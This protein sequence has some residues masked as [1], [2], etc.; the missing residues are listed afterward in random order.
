MT[1]RLTDT[2]LALARIDSPSGSEARVAAYLTGI[3]EDAG[4]AVR[5]DDSRALTGADTGNLIAVIEGDGSSATLVLSA[6]MD[7]V[8]P[9][10]GVEPVVKEGVV[11]SAGE[12]VLG[13]DDK[14][15][16]AAI[17]EASRRLIESGVARP[18]IRLVITVSEEIGL[19]G[20]K[21]LD[22]HDVHGDLCLVLDA[23]GDPGGIVVAAPTHYTFAATFLG[24][25][26]HAG[27]YPELGH[28]AIE[29]AA[30]AIARMELGR[31]D[32]EST[33]NIG[34]IG[35]GGATNVVPAN[36]ELTGECR[37]LDLARVEEIRGRMDA[38]MRTAAIEGGGAVQ[39]AW[40]KEYDGYRF[41]E[42][43]AIL[44]LVTLAC[45]DAGLE[46]KTFE[47]GG[48]SDANIISALGVPT[49]ALSSGMRDVHSTS[50][51]IRLDDM[52][53][54]TRLVMAAAVRLVEE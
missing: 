53:A 28:S 46:P 12:T 13:A 4:F 39:I 41:A 8:Q 27:V 51:S 23:D 11:T 45:R 2:F 1:D 50:E 29:M 16:I 9:C 20:A 48:G 35:G 49:L 37:S 38:A 32:P 34:S 17:V 54:L 52:E 31:L 43:D 25:A 30:N 5:F 22:A 6:H 33:A 14:A 10:E 21:A 3:L 19:K 47:T 7:C 24:T 44:S 15:G 18:A 36:V 42:D 40:T 26:A